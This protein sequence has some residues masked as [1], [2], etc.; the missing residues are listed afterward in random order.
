VHIALCRVVIVHVP[1]HLKTYGWLVSGEV[2]D[3]GAH[4]LFAQVESIASLDGCDSQDL[5][6]SQKVEDVHGGLVQLD[7]YRGGIKRGDRDN[8]STGIHLIGYGRPC[9]A[10][11]EHSLPTQ[12]HILRSHHPSVYRRY[13]MECCVL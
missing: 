6:S 11:L 9:N 1:L 5:T 10:N 8:R 4:G 13:V 7:R 3:A 2:H 12:G